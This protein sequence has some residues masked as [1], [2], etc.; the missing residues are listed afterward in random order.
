MVRGVI[1][2][3]VTVS[4]VLVCACEKVETT[5]EAS[6][7]KIAE[8]GTPESLRAELVKGFD[9]NRADENGMTILHHAALGDNADVIEMLTE[10]YQANATIKDN[11]GRTPLDLARAEKKWKAARALQAS[12]GE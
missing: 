5:G 4:T 7:Y 12:A 1:L 9:I 8:T 10:E 11:Q 6:I 3:F 2:L